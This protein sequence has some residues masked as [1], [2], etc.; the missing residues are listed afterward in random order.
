MLEH[1]GRLREAAR[2]YDIP[3]ADWLD[4]STG[5]APW[6]FPLP[7]IPEQAWTR[8]PESD[9][10]LEAAACLYYGAE[11]VLPLAGSQA[12]IQ[13]LPRLRRG[14][15]VGVLS[16]CYA[17]HA[18]AWRQAGHLVREVGE[19]EVEPYL[20]SLDVLLVV[21]PNNP[22]GRVFEPAELLAWHAR[23]QRRGGW[24]LVDEAFMDC[25]PQS[26]LAACSNRPGLIVLR[27]FGKFFGLA[28]ARLGFALGERPLLQALAEQLGP[29]TVN[30]PVRHVAQ[31]ALRDRQQQRQQRERLLAASQR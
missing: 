31:S 2:R 3:L 16:P 21:N 12:A 1:G 27:S 9:D 28:G 6:P 19:A 10:G 25:T 15:R 24:L 4:L 26:S 29:W 22:T 13:A 18:H 23:L 17:E 11:R 8:L 30:G 20:D 7:A 5:I 14:G